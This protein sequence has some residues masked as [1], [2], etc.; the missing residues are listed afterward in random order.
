MHDDFDVEFANQRFVCVDKGFGKMT[1]VD[2]VIRPEDIKFGQ[3][4]KMTQLF[5][6]SKK[7]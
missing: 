4:L 7:E 5:L 3:I 1:P 2:V 6:Q